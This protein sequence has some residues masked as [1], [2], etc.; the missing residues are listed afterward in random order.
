MAKLINKKCVPC[1]GVTPKLAVEEIG[2]Y[3]A[4]LQT[5]WSVVKNLKIERL[6]KFNNFKEAIEFVNKI[7][8]LAEEE[9]HHPDMDISY[10]EVNITIWTHAIKGLS[11]NDFILAVKIDSLN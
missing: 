1:E 4:E 2:E 8:I 7:A 11:E 3:M 5:G 6:F 9:G 10:N